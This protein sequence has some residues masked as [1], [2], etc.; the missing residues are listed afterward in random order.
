MGL[1]NNS[2]PY[3]NQFGTERKEGHERLK[4]KVENPTNLKSNSLDCLLPDMKLKYSTKERFGNN[5]G[6]GQ[7]RPVFVVFDYKGVLTP[8]PP[9]VVMWE[10]EIFLSIFVLA[11]VP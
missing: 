1:E 7:K 8:P 2:L 10:S 9:F 11:W 4:F 6:R 5:K 3:W